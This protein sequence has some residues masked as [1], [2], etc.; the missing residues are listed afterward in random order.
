MLAL[1]NGCQPVG[2]D[3]TYHSLN[4]QRIYTLR[5]VVID[6]GRIVWE[7][8]L[9]SPLSSCVI[10]V[11]LWWGMIT[12]CRHCGASLVLHFGAP[13][14]PP[15][16]RH[17][18]NFLSVRARSA[19]LALLQLQHR[20]L[21]PC[22]IQPRHRPRSL[23]LLHLQI[24]QTVR[25]EWLDFSRWRSALHHR[26]PISYLLVI[27]TQIAELD[28]LLR[29]LNPM[30][31]RFLKLTV[32]S[33]QGRRRCMPTWAIFLEDRS[34]LL[35]YASCILL[36]CWDISAKLRISR[37]IWTIIAMVSF[38]PFRVSPLHLVVSFCSLNQPVDS[39]RIWGFSA[40]LV[41]LDLSCRACVLARVH[42]WWVFLSHLVV[43]IESK[44]LN[45]CFYDFVLGFA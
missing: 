9:K 22:Q 24:L 40:K 29:S 26:S 32:N 18:P 33:I 30:S 43:V 41:E 45:F 38:I 6:C 3:T 16:H 31:G 10:S 1:W 23:T 36:W 17:T 28:K 25:R 12:G 15:A 42:H 39:I 7:W 35:S 44:G 11:M 34:R 2:N 14:R 27:L 8:F 21:Q 19:C 13:L 37:R 5:F 4:R 20:H